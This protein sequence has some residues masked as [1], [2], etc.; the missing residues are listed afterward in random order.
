MQGRGNACAQQ[1]HNATAVANRRSMRRG[2]GARTE[3]VER[4]C[5]QTV[6]KVRGQPREHRLRHAGGLEVLHTHTQTNAKSGSHPQRTAH[7][8]RTAATTSSTYLSHRIGH[9]RSSA[10][11][12]L[13]GHREQANSSPAAANSPHKQHSRRRHQHDNTW[14]QCRWQHTGDKKVY[15][16]KRLAF[17]NSCL[18]ASL[19]STQSRKGA[20]LSVRHSSQC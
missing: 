2:M 12:R 16:A 11:P 6:H 7:A 20:F 5:S 18:L 4:K 19:R 17:A 10:C 15:V 14:H 9:R 8:S 13:A 1:E 3:Q